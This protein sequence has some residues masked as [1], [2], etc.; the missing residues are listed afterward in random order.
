MEQL[1]RDVEKMLLEGATEES[2]ALVGQEVKPKHEIR[3]SGKE[4]DEKI[5]KELNESYAATTKV[6]LDPTQP[7]LT[8]TPQTR[9]TLTVTQTVPAAAP[10]I[11]ITPTLP[12]LS[13]SLAEDDID[14]DVHGSGEEEGSW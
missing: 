7:Q 2:M 3:Q 11:A 14:G 12:Q 1:S 9:T 4:K 10:I 6:S 13:M 8:I 5:P